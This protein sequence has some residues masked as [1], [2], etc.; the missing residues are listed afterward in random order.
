MNDYEK[1]ALIRAGNRKSHMNRG[2]PG[3]LYDYGVMHVNSKLKPDPCR[4][5][6]FVA[7]C[8]ETVH[9]RELLTPIPSCIGDRN[10]RA[11]NP[12]GDCSQCTFI[13]E[14][15]EVILEQDLRNA[16]A[17]HYGST[18]FSANI[19]KDE[20]ERSSLPEHP[21]PAIPQDKSHAAPTQS[22][23]A[24]TPPAP[25]QPTVVSPAPTPAAPPTTAAPTPPTPP[26]TAATPPPYRF[27]FDDHD[28]QRRLRNARKLADV[29]LIN[30]IDRLSFG[31]LKG[32]R[33]EYGNVARGPLCAMSIVLNERGLL[34]PRFRG[35]R[36]LQ[37]Y[38]PGK[39]L[40]TDETHLSNDR[41]VID[42]HW[43]WCT[44]KSRLNPKPPLGKLFAAEV[45]DF[46]QASEFVR[47]HGAAAEKAARL[48]LSEEQQLLLA[49]LH[50]KEVKKR[51]QTIS[52]G[53][54]TARERITAIARRPT[55]RLDESAI[56]QLVAVQ[57]ALRIGRGSPT[58]AERLLPLIAGVQIP[59]KTVADQKRW[60]KKNELAID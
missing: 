16:P 42:L 28:T 36:R 18:D 47:T 57:T 40:T 39:T 54:E 20:F 49:V 58:T 43:L 32:E 4:T 44:D 60:L 30:G 1:H 35:M 38:K 48:R 12:Y 14:C 15:S 34:A 25:A 17:G 19:R 3:C 56:E 37:K 7:R 55:S 45:F 31:T 46:D 26:T 51:W 52:E 24:A 33:L 27:P 53:E 6:L 13:S 9:L 22:S 2:D 21:Q 59:R 29:D 11:I 23:S 50:N 5:C 41:Q 8:E 10:K